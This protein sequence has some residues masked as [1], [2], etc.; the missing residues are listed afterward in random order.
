VAVTGVVRPLRRTDLPACRRLQRHLA[1]PSPRLLD[2]PVVV[3]GHVSLA[4]GRPVGYVLAVGGNE[5][6]H[7]AELVVAPDHRR[8]GRGRALLERAVTGGDGPVT[9]AVEP[10]NE[11]AR[12][13]YGS[14]GFEERERREGYFASGDALLLAR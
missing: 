14:L 8:E 4:E 9:V 3:D 11:A 12:A 2:P 5:G 10:D 13:L 1:E 6:T 7:V